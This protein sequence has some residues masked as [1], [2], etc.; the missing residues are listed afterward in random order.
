[1]ILVRLNRL[2]LIGA[3]LLIL[4]DFIFSQ[5]S[6]FEL[7][8]RILNAENSEPVVS[9]LVLLVETN[10]YTTSSSDGSFN[11]SN[12]K[13][14]KFRIKI[15]HLGFQEKLIDLNLDEQTAKTLTIYLIPKTINLSPVVISGNSR[16]SVVEEI[17][18]YSSVLSGKE[19]QRSLSQTLA[20]TLKNEAGLSIRSMGPAPSRPVF[21]GLGQ[22][23][24]LISEDGIK[25]T[26]LSGTS[27][28]HAVTLEPFQSDRIE[29]LRGP[30]VLTKTSTTVGGVVNV[31]KNDIPTQIHNQFHLNLGGYY[32]SANKG[33]LTGF[34]SEIPYN[35]LALKLELSRRKTDDLKTPVGYLKNSMSKN[36]NSNVGLSFIDDFGVIGSGFKIYNLNYG[37]PGGFIGAHPN[38]VNIDIEKQQINFLSEIKLKSNILDFKFSNVQYRHKEFEYNGLIGSEFA[39]VTN[40]ANLNFEHGK[41]S[42]FDEG[43]IGLSFEHRDFNIGGYVFSPPSYSYNISTYIY[44]NF[45]NERFNFEVGL[46]YSNDKVIPRRKKISS[47]IGKIDD[48]EFNNISISGALLYQLSDVVF[49]GMNLSKSS[50]V[51]T[52][53]ELFSDGPHLAAY[54]YEVGNPTL[55]SE[56]GYGAEFYVYQKFEKLF[57]NLNFFFNYFDY[58]IIPQN[59]G[60]INYQTFL[61]IYE[62][63]GV[64]AA[65]FGF[66]GSL[67]WRIFE[68]INFV[69]SISFVN[70]YFVNSKLPLP[71]IPPLKGEL[72][73]RY[74]LSNLSAG[75][76]IEWSTAQV[77]VDEF[78]ERT[79]GY[80]ILNLFSQYIFQTGNFVNN[81]GLSIEN[82][83][84]KEYRN[85]LSRVKSILPEAGVN[86]R[87]IYKLM[88]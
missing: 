80:A 37:I 45:K 30:K 38:G 46:R 16:F 50:R 14:N 23:R 42:L 43:I 61:P 3:I 73:L 44:E 31:V 22:E 47:R 49:L 33:Y 55:Q 53:E 27:P 18:Q 19:L 57:F 52:I 5:S 56:S 12:I 77:R 25:T 48:R 41:F 24:V 71:Q 76:F 10:Q 64:E 63:R 59:T 70:G 7:S 15:T 32:E 85:H 2:K 68:N 67:D 66:D 54:S 1:M 20:S 13:I 79:A 58:F 72:G 39:I 83:F 11:F 69:N 82:L 35:P 74:S 87:I 34:Q 84:N 17:Q 28:D 81:I 29:V 26:D 78:E 86:F 21:R 6:Y 62:T 88:I 36:L 40:S 75:I 8:G 4:S 51:P 9:A 60:R 65:Q